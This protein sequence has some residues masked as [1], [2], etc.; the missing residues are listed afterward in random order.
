M[1]NYIKVH[2]LKLLETTRDVNQNVLMVK[3]NTHTHTH[4]QSKYVSTG[5]LL[6]YEINTIKVYYINCDFFSH[7]NGAT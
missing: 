4:T 6:V 1:K 7:E 2:S 5:I 3:R